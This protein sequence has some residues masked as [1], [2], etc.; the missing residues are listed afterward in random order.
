MAL[1]DRFAFD[2]GTGPG[3]NGF[4]PLPVHEFQASL[5]LFAAPAPVNVGKAAIIATWGLSENPTPD[6]DELQLDELIANRAAL[7]TLAEQI[8][9]VATI[10][11]VL[12]MYRRDLITKVQAET[13]L[14]L[15]LT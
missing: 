14:G 12:F 5:Q 15:T 1:I 11:S 13:W 6:A 7:V 2:A 3:Q 10:N 8:E 9:Y 4:E